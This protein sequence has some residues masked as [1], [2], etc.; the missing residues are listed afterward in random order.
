MATFKLAVM[1][2]D[3]IGKETVPEA[4]K[5]LEAA[6]KKYGGFELRPTELPWNSDYY[7]KHGRMMP[8][9]G[10]QQLR[11]FDAILFGAVGDKRVPE[12]VSV[13]QTI[14][15]MRRGLD[16]WANIR[17]G[18]LMPGA[19]CPLKDKEP[20]Q[21]D[22]VVV[23]ENTEGEYADVGGNLFANTPHEVAVQ[24]AVFTRRGTERILRYGFELARKRKAQGAGKGQLVSVSKQNAQRHGQVFWHRVF[25]EVRE[26]YPD[27]ES[28]FLYIDAACMDM[29]RKPETFDVLVSSN[30]FGD[31]LT[32]LAGAIVGGLGIAP[33]ANLNPDKAAPSM[34]EPVHG[35][36]PDI[37]G[38]GIAN[39][40]GSVMAAAMMLDFLGQDQA[41]QGMVRAVESV[42][43][44]AKA[45]KTPD[46]GGKAKTREVGDEI[47]RRV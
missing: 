28:R 20:G 18:R 24:S 39:P 11:A 31:I 46:F 41:A 15:A 23:R 16:Q 40:F 9:D 38:K 29:V 36:A 33:S 47:A 2:G 26:E 45:P 32:D 8:E 1:A 21:I 17:P 44:D 34:F 42:L 13:A 35:S 5:V 22:F 19:P 14:L 4:L 25:E 30:L 6:A 27:I 7:E 10:I 37:A 12:H 3:G 43:S